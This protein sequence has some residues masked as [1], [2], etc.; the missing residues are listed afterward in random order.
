MEAK[1]PKC[2]HKFDTDKVEPKKEKECPK[3]NSTA[4]IPIES[5]VVNGR[6][7]YR[8]LCNHCSTQSIHWENV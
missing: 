6:K 7:Y 1:C 3:C 4:L 2:N 8:F 5:S